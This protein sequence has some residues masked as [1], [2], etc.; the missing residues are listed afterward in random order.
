M[1]I[2]LC[3][4][5]THSYPQPRTWVTVNTRWQGTPQDKPQDTLATRRGFSVPDRFVQ[6]AE[7]AC[8]PEYSSGRVVRLHK[9]YCS[10]RESSSGGG[11]HHAMVVSGRPVERGRSGCF[12]AV[13]GGQ[14]RLTIPA[15]NPGWQPRKSGRFS[16]GCD[17]MPFCQLFSFLQSFAG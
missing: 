15:S 1:L 12:N 13:S 4:K 14:P 8:P 16:A 11:T 6:Y 2:D 3:T 10:W 7:K 9:N 5:R 17:V